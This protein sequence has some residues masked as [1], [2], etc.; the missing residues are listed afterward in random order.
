M[1]DIII[2]LIDTDALNR[3]F[4]PSDNP[5]VPITGAS[6][7]G[8]GAPSTSQRVPITYSGLLSLG[9]HIPSSSTATYSLSPFQ[10]ASL[11]VLLLIQV[12]ALCCGTS[13]KTYRASGRVPTRRVA[14]RRNCL[15]GRIHLYVWPT[16]SRTQFQIVKSVHHLSLLA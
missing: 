14:I 7:I 1:C 5:R 4:V 6:S 10:F 11:V 3:V 13:G 2:L 9:L 16:R 8:L 15:P 12:A